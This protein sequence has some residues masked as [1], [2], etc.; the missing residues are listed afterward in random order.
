MSLRDTLLQLTPS[1]Y[2]RF[3]SSRSQVTLLEMAQVTF[4]S[5]STQP[6]TLHGLPWR[7]LLTSDVF[8][9][10][11]ESS[12]AKAHSHTVRFLSS[13]IIYLFLSS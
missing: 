13:S 11:V 6:S 8:G 5:L 7:H 3:I 4:I 2:P 1:S 12:G 9:E 10:S